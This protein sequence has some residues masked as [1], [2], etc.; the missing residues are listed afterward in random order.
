MVAVQPGWLLLYR[1]LGVDPDAALRRA[2]LPRDLFLRESAKLTVAEYFR[3]WAASETEV[4]EPAFPIRLAE[5]ITSEAFHP[6]VFAALCSPNLAVAM[7][8]IATYKRLVVPMTV[9]VEAGEGDLVVSKR[10]D[11]DGESL[12][13]ASLA[14][15]ELVLLVEIARMGLRE[16][17]VP[18]SVTS[19]LPMEPAEAYTSY[20]GVTPVRGA[21]RS[22]T[23][24]AEDAKKP[25]LTASAAVWQTFEPDLQHRLSKLDP[26][27]SLSERV[28]SILLES[29]PSGEASIEVTGQRLGLSPRTLQRRLSGEGTSYK[30]IVRQTREQLA[31]HYVSNTD[32]PYVEIGFLLGYEEPN[33]FFRAFRQWTGATPEQTRSAVAGVD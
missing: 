17:V 23:F 16:R 6:M 8:R 15:V 11:G 12:V 13:P 27:A 5:A 32:L 33:S 19:H 26:S 30:E 29:L 18:V 31:H 25:F 1:D 3:L 21:A 7:G 28:R 14:A 10:W 20:L 9:T 2:E 24:R 4:G 22:V